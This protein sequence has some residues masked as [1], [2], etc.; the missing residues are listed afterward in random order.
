LGCGNDF[1]GPYRADERAADDVVERH[2]LQALRSRVS[3]RHTVV[4]QRIVGPALKP[5]LPVPVGGAMAEAKK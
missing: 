4:V 1:S 3:L 2:V 5:S